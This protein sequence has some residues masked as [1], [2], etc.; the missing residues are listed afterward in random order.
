MALLIVLPQKIRYLSLSDLPYG[1]QTSWQFAEQV[2][3]QETNPLHSLLTALLP[4]LSLHAVVALVT[5]K[6]QKVKHE[7][8]RSLT[9]FEI[10]KRRIVFFTPTDQEANIRSS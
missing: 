8:Y 5:T 10:G 1:Q 4:F 9:H 7:A 6:Q 3:A 2:P